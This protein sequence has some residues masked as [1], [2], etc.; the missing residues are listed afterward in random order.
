M[1]EFYIIFENLISENY[2]KMIV[3]TIKEGFF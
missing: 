1:A 2:L 3:T